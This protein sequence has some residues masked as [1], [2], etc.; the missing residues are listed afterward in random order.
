MTPFELDCIRAE[1][2]V[3]TDAVCQDLYLDGLTDGAMGTKPQRNEEPYV[4][5]Y[6]EGIRRTRGQEVGE[7]RWSSPY[8]KF[9]FGFV[10]GIGNGTDGESNYEF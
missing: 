6:A 7:I 5:G 1:S 4:L 3:K 10:D 9:A 8:Q 2:E